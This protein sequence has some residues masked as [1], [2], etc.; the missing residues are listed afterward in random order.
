[1]NVSSY[2]EIL[3]VMSDGDGIHIPS[4]MNEEFVMEEDNDVDDDDDGRTL[5][6]DI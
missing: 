5:C 3:G 2:G 1:V 4:P 6:H